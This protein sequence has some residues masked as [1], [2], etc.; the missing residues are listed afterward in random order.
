M[1]PL[2]PVVAEAGMPNMVKLAICA[3][4]AHVAFAFSTVFEVVFAFGAVVDVAFAFGAGVVDGGEDAGEEEVDTKTVTTSVIVEGAADTVIVAVAVVVV[5]GSVSVCV[6][7]CMSVTVSAAG[8]K[9]G[10]G[11]NSNRESLGRLG[12]LGWDPRW[13]R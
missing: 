6:C 7:V 9:E 13:A 1:L 10:A 4:A 8:C 2:G 3:G 5:G 11:G 12:R